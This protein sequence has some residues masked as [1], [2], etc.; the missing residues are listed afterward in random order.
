MKAMA[1]TTYGD[2]SGFA[3]HHIDRPQVAAGQVR[4]KVAAT[5]VNPIDARIRSG[6]MPTLAPELPA[7]LHGDVAGVVEEVGEGVTT[8]HPGD[9]VYGFAGGLRGFGGA[10]AEYM[11][12]D[13]RLI[14]HKPKTLTMAEAASLPCVAV[15]AW[16]GLIERA[17]LRPGQ[18]VLV[19]G[20]A[21]GVGHVALQLAAW[22][23]AEVYAT[24]STPAK[25]TIARDL[26]ARAAIAYREIA[27]RDYVRAYTDG[28]GFDVVF[29]TVGKSC[30]DAS[31][32][33][34]AP[35]GSVIAIAA[36]STHDLSPLH[37]KGLTLH[38]V[39]TILPLLTGEGMDNIGQALAKLAPVIDSGHIRPLIDSRQFGFTEAAEAHRLLESG[40]VIGKVVLV[41]DL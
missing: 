16:N 11:V 33:A 31:F 37:A 32:E 10:L 30:L 39:F 35:G 41:N 8:F 18:R 29:D 6:M 9:E 19:H 13:A 12:A 2:P 17:T 34:A 25:Q 7:L 15:T 40:D 36:R 27:V 23:G 4:I 1:L 5:S 14:A 38:V 20:A 28:R 21:G 24:A 26:G 3:L 22:A